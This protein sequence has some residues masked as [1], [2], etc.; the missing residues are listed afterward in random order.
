MISTARYLSNQEFFREL[1]SSKGLIPVKID[2]K[3]GRM[4]WQDLGQ[5]HNYE[6]FFSISLKTIEGLN[7]LKK[8]RPPERI[9]TDINVL[10]SDLVLTDYVYP[11]G[12]IFHAGRCGSTLLAKSLAK[13][14][15]NLVFGEAEPH[16]AIWN[17]ITDN[18]RKIAD[19]TEQ[20]VQMYRRLILAMGRKRLSSH[21][22][23]FV[24]FTS[25]SVLLFDFIKAVFPDV[26]MIF[27]YRDPVA[28]LASFEKNPPAWLK[29]RSGPFGDFIVGHWENNLPENSLGTYCEN[30]I[31]RFFEAAL[32]AGN[33]GMRYLNYNFLTAHHLA[34]ILR[35]FDVA[36]TPE[37]LAIMQTQ[38]EYYSKTDFSL[39]DYDA[40]TQKP[41][42]K[43]ERTGDAIRDRTLQLY[44]RLTSSDLNIIKS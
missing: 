8:D 35:V 27:L 33:G 16:N 17:I 13:S 3:R 14:R 28:M 11:T 41:D 24:K 9:E 18:W 30:A 26:P 32:Q 37:E 43:G 36:I 5:Y 23:H 6:G 39:R 38:F 40:A 15:S 19:P 44:Q 2:A 21:K 31:S 1:N 20:Y 12:F 42:E 29:H 4:I 7:R 10:D 25:F 22:N 34:E